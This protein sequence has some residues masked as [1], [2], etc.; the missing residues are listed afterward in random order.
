VR[1]PR[2]TVMAALL[3]KAQA[4][5]PQ[6]FATITRVATLDFLDL[7]KVDFPQPGLMFVEHDE[8]T[9]PKGRGLPSVLVVEV[10]VCI[11]AMKPRDPTSPSDPDR[12]VPGA[13]IINPLIEAVENQLF[14]VDRP[15]EGVCTLGGLVS[16]AWIEGRTVKVV[17]DITPNGQCFAALP[18]R[19]MFP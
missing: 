18:V 7:S 13:S 9:T 4:L 16:H 10:L 19:V 5:N 2:E 6:P 8:D 15:M 14:A 17:G 11:Y 3:A 1:V 12:S